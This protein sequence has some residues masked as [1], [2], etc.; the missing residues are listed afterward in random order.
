MPSVRL[1][2]SSERVQIVSTRLQENQVASG[3]TTGEH[4]NKTGISHNV[5]I[6]KVDT[7]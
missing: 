2:P 4:G 3:T 7:I 6:L 1:H 5:G